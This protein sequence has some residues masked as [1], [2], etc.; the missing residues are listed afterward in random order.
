METYCTDEKEKGFNLVTYVH[1]E[2]AYKSDAHA[3]IRAIEL[4][5]DLTIPAQ[6]VF[7]DFLYRSDDNCEKAKKH[8]V[9]LIAPL[10]GTPK[11]GDLSLIYD[12]RMPLDR[13][14]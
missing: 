11:E 10:M 9:E 14:L 7:A 4:V 12:M 2:P 1:V 3:L 6:K 8:G 13:Y 5:K